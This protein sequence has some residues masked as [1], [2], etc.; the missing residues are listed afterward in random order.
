MLVLFLVLHV[1]LFS[2]HLSNPRT[3]ANLFLKSGRYCKN[4]VST[5]Q[6]TANGNLMYFYRH[7]KYNLCIGSKSVKAGKWEPNENEGVSIEQDVC[8]VNNSC[9]LDYG[10]ICF[11]Q[12]SIYQQGIAG[13]VLNG[14]LVVDAK[15][16]AVLFLCNDSP[17]YTV[18][19]GKGN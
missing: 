12:D 3:S 14:C 1:G 6:P 17:L 10:K 2:R 4:S 13:N 8:S 5:Y 9:K 7:G 16:A 18:Q 19:L 11:L 15:L